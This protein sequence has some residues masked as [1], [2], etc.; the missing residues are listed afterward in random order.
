MLTTLRNH[1]NKQP[2]NDNNQNSNKD[3]AVP[4]T[5]VVYRPGLIKDLKVQNRYILMGIK[6]VLEKITSGD[7]GLI[8][9]L[10]VRVQRMIMSQFMKEQNLL[11]LY[12]KTATKNN[13]AKQS[14][15]KTVKRE[16]SC[17]DSTLFMFFNTYLNTRLTHKHLPAMRR[18]L[19]VIGKTLLWSFGR[20][21]KELYSM[22]T[23]P[24]LA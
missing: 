21:E 24:Q 4:N 15:I 18:E 8:R 20:K 16:M 17:V 12:V 13:P 23:A 22:Y 1:S 6:L 2:S 5:F 3:I 7:L 11:Y 19:Y 9:E 10:L 14:L